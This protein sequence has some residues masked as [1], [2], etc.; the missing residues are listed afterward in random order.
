MADSIRTTGK[1]G[2]EV[3]EYKGEFS[4]TAT[5]E[6]KDGKMW[7]QWGKVRVG[8]DS[9]SEKDRPF[10]CIL[11]DKTTAEAVLLTALKEITGAT[12]VQQ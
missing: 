7:Q 10:K 5:Y 2:I 3:S 11:G 8:K 6:G 1:N 4:L 12:W 9:Y